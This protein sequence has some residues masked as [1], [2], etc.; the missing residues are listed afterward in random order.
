MSNS[1][2]LITQKQ[3]KYAAI[4]GLAFLYVYFVVLLNEYYKD[5]VEYFTNG[6]IHGFDHARPGKEL[7]FYLLGGSS[8]ISDI[9]PIPIFL[10][11]IL[12][13]YGAILLQKRYMLDYPFWGSLAGLF[14]LFNPFYIEVL[15]FNLDALN[16]TLS[17]LISILI[18][19]NAV[20][21]QRSWKRIVLSICF[22]VISLSIYQGVITFLLT[23][24][25][26]NTMF[27]VMLKVS[28]NILIKNFFIILCCI[29]FGQFIS[30]FII[31]PWFT[32]GEYASGHSSLT[33]DPLNMWLTIK[34]NINQFNRLLNDVLTLPMF[35]SLVPI[36][37]YAYIQFI[38]M[39]RIYLKRYQTVF[40][41]LLWVLAIFS[42]FLLYLMILGPLLLL[43]ETVLRARVLIGFGLILFVGISIFVMC[44]KN[45]KVYSYLFV[46]VFYSMILI[47]SASNA[48]K[49]HLQHQD[50]IITFM[51]KDIIDKVDL[52]EITMVY[53]YGTLPSFSLATLNST[54]AYHIIWQ[55]LSNT[56]GGNWATVGLYQNLTK[57]GLKLPYVPREHEIAD[58]VNDKNFCKN[59][60]SLTSNGNYNIYI[61]N[62]ILVLDWQRCVISYKTMPTTPQ[63]I[64]W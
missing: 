29:I 3:L 51:Y 8:I 12:S 62:S 58:I 42:P 28:P 49:S 48:Q 45:K 57:K 53:T 36:L 6:L 16:I 37:I 60:N 40:R 54:N 14:I 46:P 24:L 11:A 26:V 52:N 56:T 38:N 7:L 13:A 17:I 47:S 25:M 19:C 33:F 41:P 20:Y 23:L 10:T 34:F 59:F 30:L 27:E 61:V 22:V 50:Q 44:I 43:E 63:G 39:T 18:F 4:F 2:S 35:I 15:F 32:L 31:T 64:Y 55:F 1:E 21:Y 9:R 5:D